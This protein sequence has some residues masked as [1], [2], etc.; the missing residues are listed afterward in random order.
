VIAVVGVP[1][2]SNLPAESASIRISRDY[3]GRRRREAVWIG[4]YRIA[5]RDSSK[6]LGKAWTKRSRPAHGYLTR[7]EAHAALDRFPPLA[8]GTTPVRRRQ[9]CP[10]PAVAAAPL[11]P[12]G[13]RALGAGARSS[14]DAGVPER[15]A[16]RLGPYADPVR[17]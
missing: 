5:G 10:R 17:P 7:A 8:A 2:G 15:V 4:R 9:I 11:A 14:Q 3:K 13:G 12:I 1:A 6:V 16:P